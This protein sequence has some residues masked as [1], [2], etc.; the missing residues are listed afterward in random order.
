MYISIPMSFKYFTV[1]KRRKSIRQHHGQGCHVLPFVR[2]CGTLWPL[3]LLQVCPQRHHQH[4]TRRFLFCG[5]CWRLGED[6]EVGGSREY[7][8]RVNT[9]LF[10]SLFADPIFHKLFGTKYPEYKLSF[11]KK[12]SEKGDPKGV[13][14]VSI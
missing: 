3:H 12:L 8:Q 11:T 13:C 4:G 7:R 6:P 9:C 2:Q 10:C 1:E 5:V 14:L